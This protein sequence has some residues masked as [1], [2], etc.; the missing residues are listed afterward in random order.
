MFFETQEQYNKFYDSLR[1]YAK[2]KAYK[3]FPDLGMR[4]DAIDKALEKAE[5]EILNIHSHENIQGFARVIVLNS[6][7]NSVRDRKINLVASK[8]KLKG[9]DGIGFSK[10]IA[11]KQEIDDGK[12]PK[13]NILEIEDLKERK[14]CIDYFYNNLSQEEIAK[15]IGLNQSNVSRAIAKY[16][17]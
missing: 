8:S 10:T 11:F 17:K 12:N 5:D 13:V 2:S 1:K 15:K 9:N 4:D 6:L 14:I 7:K 3:M 16:T